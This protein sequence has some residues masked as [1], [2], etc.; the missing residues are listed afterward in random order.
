MTRREQSEDVAA[1]TLAIVL[2]AVGFATSWQWLFAGL[3]VAALVIRDLVRKLRASNASRSASLPE[4]TG[5]ARRLDPEFRP[6]PGSGRHHPCNSEGPDTPSGSPDLHRSTRGTIP[7]DTPIFDE[8]E[9]ENILA[10]LRAART[11]RALALPAWV[12]LALVA[13]AL[14]AVMLVVYR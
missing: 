6:M 11:R 1:C 8:L 14:L 2:L 4:R 10:R 5:R 12:V 9:Q 7:M 13:G 3:I